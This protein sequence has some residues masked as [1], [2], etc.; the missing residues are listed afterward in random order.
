MMSENMCS[1]SDIKG[2]SYIVG[3][4]RWDLEPKDL[5]EPRSRLTEEGIKYSSPPEGYIFYIDLMGD[6]PALFLMRHTAI[7]FGKTLARIDEIPQEL[8]AEAL[9]ENKDRIKFGMCPISVKI[10]EW[11]KKE[12]GV[13]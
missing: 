4:I 3:G 12:L 10:E 7:N 2:E 5:M 9:E 6:K 8:L 13:L 1:L 11:L